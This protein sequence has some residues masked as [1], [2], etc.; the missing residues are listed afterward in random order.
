MSRLES[1]R[2][3]A[4]WLIEAGAVPVRLEAQK[5]KPVGLAWGA[6]RP[7]PDEFTERDNIGIKVGA[8]S[9]LVDVDLDCPE[10]LA[11]AEHFL[12]KTG[13]V[14]GRPSAPRSHPWYR[15]TDASECAQFQDPTRIGPDKAK[16]MIVEFRGGTNDDQRQTMIPPSIH[17]DGET[18]EWNERK[19]AAKVDGNDLLRAVSKLA[20]ASILAR[21]WPGYRHAASLALCGALTRAGWTENEVVAFVVAIASYVN[22]DDGEPRK[23]RQQAKD[24]ARKLKADKKTTG[25]PTLRTLGVPDKVIEKVR[26]WLAL[27]LAAMNGEPSPDARAETQASGDWT[28]PKPVGDHLPPVAAFKA[29]LLPVDLRDWVLDIAE[30]MQVPIDL[31]A[32]NAMCALSVVA[33][34]AR[35]IQPKQFDPW[36]VYPILWGAGIAPPSSMKTPAAKFAIKPLETLEIRAR[37]Q[38]KAMKAQRDVAEMVRNAQLAAIKKQVDTA[39]KSG[40]VPDVAALAG[41]I[42]DEDPTL[43]R[44]R[45]YL[46]QDS[47]VEKIQDLVDRGPKSRSYPLAIFRDEL[48]GFLNTFEKDGREGDRHFYLEG[49]GVA[50]RAVD[51]IG[52]G[53]IFTKDLSLI[54]FGNT[55]PGPFQS[56]VREAC[57]GGDGADGLLQR[58]QLMVYPDPITNW[59]LVDRSENRMAA[60]RATDLFE[61]LA[62]IFE[63]DKD[64][65]P[66]ALR[67]TAEA[68][69]IFNDWLTDLTK[70]LGDRDAHPALVSH[71]GKYRS[72]MPAIALV[73][74]LASGPGLENEPVSAWAAKTAI[75]WCTYLGSHAIRVY[76]IAADPAHAI[77][78]VIAD[79]IAAGKW[80]GTVKRREIQ[81]SLDVY[82]AK[83]IAAAVEL[84]EDLGW[85]RIGEVRG[86]GEGGAPSAVVEINPMA[87]SS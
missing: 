42:P 30:R 28:Q 77:A 79:R 65:K 16:A 62:N 26:E 27:P 69:K 68:Q 54:V 57:R 4:Q 55:T 8:S 11:I 67:F 71:F 43:Q 46:T 44:P 12:P 6:L 15:V 10:A 7:T 20:A 29:D 3:T 51:R 48:L 13:L 80:T 78:R 9:S 47:T 84:L 24:S 49:W 1:L 81:R 82:A 39:I 58:F 87:V 21:Y 25:M 53:E 38:F 37:E 45:R 17:P 66:P 61:R 2:T 33:T 52:R 60:S 56:Y 31:V 85:L 34:S 18:L 63:S 74:H 14:H 72:L 86:G 70:R 19:M 41:D 64:G 5:K 40:E 36:R 35:T 83:D 76:S 32:I 50:N 73:L 75:E 23:R 59:T 22:K